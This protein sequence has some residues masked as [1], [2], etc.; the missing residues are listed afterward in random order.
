MTSGQKRLTLKKVES[1][2]YLGNIYKSGM[3][4]HPIKEEL[5]SKFEKYFTKLT[6]FHWNHVIKSVLSKLTF[7][8]KLNE[9]LVF[10]NYQ[11]DGLKNT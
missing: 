9:N 11:K 6:D 1:F 8:V 4:L 3:D 7:T 2:H 5:E 10:I